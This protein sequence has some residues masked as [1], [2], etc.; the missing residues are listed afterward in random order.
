MNVRTYLNQIRHF[1]AD[2]QS[3]IQERRNL[4]SSVELKTTSYNSDKVQEGGAG[5]FDEKYVKFIEVSELIN[6]KIDDLFD[7]K[8]RISNE[9]DELEKPEHRIILRLRYINLQTFEQVAVKLGYNMRHIHRLH[10]TA[11]I[12]FDKVILQ[13]DANTDKM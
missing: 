4:R 8:L 9:I 5:H 13:S 11:L 6:E 12:E 10:G 1:E 2:V 7:L 3:R